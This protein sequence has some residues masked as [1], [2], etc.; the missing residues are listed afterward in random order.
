LTISRLKSVFGNF[1]RFPEYGRQ[2]EINLLVC[3]KV[4]DS[5]RSVLADMRSNVDEETSN[6]TGREQADPVEFDVNCHTRIVSAVFRIRPDFDFAKADLIVKHSIA[7]TVSFSGRRA[8]VCHRVIVAIA[9]A[10]TTMVKIWKEYSS[11]NGLATTPITATSSNHN[12]VQ[13]HFMRSIPEHFFYANRRHDFANAAIAA[14]R[15]NS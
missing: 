10:K 2:R 8:A 13:I 7:S 6:C 15:V 9:F 12:S 11:Q 3:L 5:S 4:L 1:L 14:S